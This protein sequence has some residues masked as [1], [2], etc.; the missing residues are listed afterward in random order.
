MQSTDPTGVQMKRKFENGHK[1]CLGVAI[2]NWLYCALQGDDA[3]Y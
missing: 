3:V 2:F 1:E